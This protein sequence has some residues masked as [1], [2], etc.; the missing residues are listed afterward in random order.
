MP[1][2][3]VHILDAAA[4]PADEMMVVVADPCFIERGSVGG[5][6]APYQPRF[7]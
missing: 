5:F 6:D 2:N 4:L 1:D 7:Q 3:A